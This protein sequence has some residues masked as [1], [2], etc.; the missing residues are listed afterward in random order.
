[1]LKRGVGVALLLTL[2]ATASAQD[3]KTPYWAS[4]A[5]GEAMMRA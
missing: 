4:I 1:M 3:K 5:S 2:A